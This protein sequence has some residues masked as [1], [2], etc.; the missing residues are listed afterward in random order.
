MWVG[1]CGGG[2]ADR[3]EPP[4]LCFQPPTLAAP[5]RPLPAVDSVY[6]PNLFVVMGEWLSGRS[7]SPRRKIPAV[8]GSVTGPRLPPPLGPR[9]GLGFGKGTC[10]W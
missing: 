9:D 5:A 7:A 1:A 10:L 4:G 8:Q 2:G 6:L 3:G